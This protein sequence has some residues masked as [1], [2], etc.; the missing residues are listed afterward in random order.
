MFFKDE[1]YKNH[2][3]NKSGAYI[4]SVSRDLIEEEAKKIFEKQGFKDSKLEKQYLQIAFS[5]KTAGSVDKM[6]GY[7]T[8]E[9]NE[10]RAPKDSYSAE[11][12][13]VLNKINNTELTDMSNGEVRNFSKEEISKLIKIAKEDGASLK[14][15]RVKKE[16]GLK[17]SVKFSGVDYKEDSKS[18]GEGA[19]FVSMPAYHKIRK[20]IKALSQDKWNVI[21]DNDELLDNIVNTIAFLKDD[22]LIE[23]KLREFNL[24]DNVIK[25]LLGLEYKKFI[26]LSFKALRKIRPFQLKGQKYTNAIMSAGYQIKLEGIKNKFLR[27]PNSDDEKIAVPVVAR[28]F[29]QTRKVINALIRQYG[30]F[31][32]IN[33]ELATDLK[34]SVNSRQEIEKGQK[35]FQEQKEKYA[36][37]SKISWEYI[38]QAAVCC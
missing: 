29:A 4:N 14:Y 10:K 23:K 1:T 27:A 17:D 7:C 11:F 21:K 2:K 36:R 26:N 38:I 20:T 32:Q 28:A 35:E 25:V 31:D 5:Q 9:K 15:T 13:K 30:Q 24:E 6:V 18:K 3:R 8:F 16:L 12:F 33:I 22:A 19:E 34:N 37:K